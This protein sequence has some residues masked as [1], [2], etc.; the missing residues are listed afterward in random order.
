[1]HNFKNDIT[2]SATLQIACLSVPDQSINDRVPLYLNEFKRLFNLQFP[3]RSKRI[4]NKT[5]SKPWINN[6]LQKCIIKKNELYARKLK[7]KT[8]DAVVKYKV[9]KKELDKTLKNSKKSYFHSK[10]LKTTSNLKE[11]WDHT[12]TMRHHSWHL[13][14]P[15]KRR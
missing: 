11:R 4:H 5:L 2:L 10:M 15:L 6:D 13:D 1:M 3:V 8:E 12:F 14:V 7:L 9:Y